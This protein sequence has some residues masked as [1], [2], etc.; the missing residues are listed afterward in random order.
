[1]IVY[2]VTT[3]ASIG[4][5]VKAVF[6]DRDQAI[7]CC[8]LFER[9]EAELEEVDTEAIRISGNKKPLAEWTVCIDAGGKV[10]DCNYLYTFNKKRHFI[11]DEDG[12][13]AVY[14]TVDTD[15]PEDKVIEIALDYWGSL[16]G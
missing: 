12:S 14:L 5:K 3:Q 6:E 7:Y 1:M 10:I 15:L 11:V 2:V 13:G 9:E 8:A 16:K 4:R